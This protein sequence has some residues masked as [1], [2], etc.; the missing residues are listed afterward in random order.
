MHNPP[1]PSRKINAVQFTTELPSLDSAFLRKP[2]VGLSLSF[3][4][5]PPHYPLTLEDKERIGSPDPSKMARILP[6]P[7]S[8]FLN[9]TRLSKS[10]DCLPAYSDK[11]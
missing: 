5:L 2:R 3:N 7:A 1:P 11:K 10:L 4:V 6:S 9:N 8:A